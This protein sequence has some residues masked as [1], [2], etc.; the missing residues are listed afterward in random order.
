VTIALHIEG[1]GYLLTASDT[2]ESYPTGEKIDSGKIISAGRTDPLGSISVTGAGDAMYIDALSQDIV[3]MFQKFKGSA[4]GLEGRVRHIVRAFHNV[5]VLPL[6]GRLHDDNLPRYFLLIA[7]THRG[8]RKMWSV[9]RT[10]LIESSDF[11]CVGIGKGLATS[12]LNRLYPRYATLD[13]LAILAAYVIYRVKGSVDGCGLKTEI[14]F[15]NSSSFGIGFVPQDLIDAW[16]NLFRKYDLLEQEMFYQAM[17]FV[18]RPPAPPFPGHEEHF[19]KAFPP[20]MK[21]LPEIVS[22]IESLRAE[23]RKLPIL[24]SQPLARRTQG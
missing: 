6:M 3:Q 14:R 13:S 15:I 8:F 5:H 10:L 2:Q 1:H 20:Q 17:N 4:D 19:E 22:E 21:P 12:L 9:D 7:A 16:E 11:Y 23:F 18:E 24:P